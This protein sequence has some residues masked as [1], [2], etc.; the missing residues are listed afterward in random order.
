MKPSVLARRA[1]PAA[2]SLA[3]LLAGCGDDPDKLLASAAAYQAKGDHAAAIIQIKNALQAAPNRSGARLMLGQSLLAAGDAAGALTELRKARELGQADSEVV[4]LL[5]RAAVLQREF[6]AVTDEW[7]KTQLDQPKAQAELLTVLAMAWLGQGQTT[8]AQQ[9]VDQALAAQTNHAPAL[10]EKARLAAL[11]RRYDDALQGLEAAA[12]DPTAAAEA[13]KLRGDVLLYG[14][15]DPEA[16]LVAYRASVEGRPAFA[17]GQAAVVRTLLRQGKVAPAGEALDALK[18]QAPGRPATLYLQAQHALQANNQKA[19]HEAAQQLLR[20]TPDSPAALELAGMVEFRGNAFVQAEALLTRALTAAP[21]LNLARRAL[22]GTYLRTGQVERALAT[23]PDTIDSPNADP[24]LVALAG[25]AHMQGGDF[26]RAQ[27]YFAR[28][29]QA[30]PGNAATRTSLAM[31]RLLTGNADAALSELHTIAAED[32][33][34]VADLALVNAHLARGEADRALQAVDALER[35]RPNDASV[36]FIRGRTLLLKRDPKA[37]RAAFEQALTRDARFFA[38][39]AALAQ[40]DLADRQPQAA[41]QRFEAAM[42]AQPDSVPPVL[43]LAGLREREGGSPKEVGDLLRKAVTIA[44]NERGPRRLLVEHHL[45]QKEP[46]EALQVAQNAVAAL[47]D[48][49]DMLDV[50]GV[51]QLAS[52]EYNQAA[53]TFNRVAALQPRSAQPHLR[54]ADVH[55][56]NRDPAAAAQ[57]LRKALEIQPN[58]LVAQ[59]GLAGYALKADRVAEALAIG[60]E[61]QK[62]RPKEAAGYLLEGDIHAQKRDWTKALAAYRQGLGRAPSPELAVKAHEALLAS[63]QAAE[64]TRHAERWLKEQPRDLA[65]PFYL[66]SRAMAAKDWARA[67]A[68]FRRI[69]ELRPDHVLALNNLAWLAGEQGKP[70]A[71]ALAERAVQAAPNQ[72]AI[73]DTLALLLSKKGEHARALELQKRVVALQPDAPLFKFNLAKVQLAAGDK[74]EARRLLDELAA[75]GDQFAGQAE[76]AK[77]R[78]SL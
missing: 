28:A 35:K 42:K 6:K 32:D 56:A 74:A 70:E 44:P 33:G 39:T 5:A 78:A 46:R 25:Q 77:M 58:L 64:A 69:V 2:L 19:A 47:P 16:A 9:A 43:A 53:T 61:I 26:Q 14:K 51:A 66:G 37:A 76:V 12:Q 8:Q 59:R 60:Q 55:A 38:A 4:P 71:V 52:G 73:L 15:N 72:P 22:V 17:E 50:L 21:Q 62:Q 36:S 68:L 75:L 13:L 41:Q 10:I 11:G 27:R 49:P 57:S 67:E 7:A 54:L 45:R 34:T 40:L 24:F 18:K 23:L 63:G 3:L 1:L 30:D 65:F 31:S 29:V 48:D 20:L